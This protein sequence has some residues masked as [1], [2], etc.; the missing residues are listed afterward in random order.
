M[1]EGFTGMAQLI[2]D[3]EALGAKVEREASHVVQAH[4]NAAATEIRSAYPVKEGNLRNGVSVETVSP[5]RYRVASRA[6]HAHLYERGS[7]QRS[8]HD[9]GANRGMM[10]PKPTLIP[11]AVKQRGRMVRALVNLVRRQK[12]RGMTGTLD[13]VERGD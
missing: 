13:V 1:A 9:T 6:R 11:I 10:P 4:A 5:L 3:L 7:V 12:V 8:T 2:A